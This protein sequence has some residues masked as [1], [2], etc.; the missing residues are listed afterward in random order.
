[1]AWPTASAAFSSV[2]G[3]SHGPASDTIGTA[4]SNLCGRTLLTHASRTAPARAR[5]IRAVR[6]TI[7]SSSEHRNAEREELAQSQGAL[8]EQAQVRK[9]ELKREGP[10]M[11]A[12]SARFRQDLR[13]GHS[14]RMCY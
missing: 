1:M 8:E 2:A 9:E 7:P 13:A 12:D 11:S 4:A 6:E 14:M 3:E 10:Q 5:D